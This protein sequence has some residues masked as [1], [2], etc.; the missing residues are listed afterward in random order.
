M[1]EF[2]TSAGGISSEALVGT[3][4]SVLAATSLFK[5]VTRVPEGFM[6]IRK[7]WGKVKRDRDGNPVIESPGR[8]WQIPFAHSI[9]LQDT[10]D[11]ATDVRHAAIDRGELQFDVVASFGWR[12]SPEGDN[13]YKAFCLTEGI[14]N[15][16]PNICFGML[17][18]IMTSIEVDEMKKREL[19][20]AK[21]AALCLEPLAE[22]GAEM[23]RLNLHSVA[24]SVGSLLRPATIIPV[25]GSGPSAAALAVA[26]G[27]VPGLAGA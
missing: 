23:R 9:D 11:Q 13:P 2:I 12:V 8:H 14:Q 21:V 15:I 7:S 16:V 27:A 5:A 4:G 25:N 18:D 24:Q 26:S 17:F 22:F 3:G 6:G 1:Q 19:V 10:R 20:E